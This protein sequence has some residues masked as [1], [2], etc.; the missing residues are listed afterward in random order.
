M[1]PAGGQGEDW[2]GRRDLTGGEGGVEASAEKKTHKF[3]RRGASFLQ[4]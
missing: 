2:A 3:G 4:G 1:N